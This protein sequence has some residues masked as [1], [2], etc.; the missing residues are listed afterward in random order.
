M[1]VIAHELAHVFLEYRTYG[2]NAVSDPAIEVKADS[3]VRRWGFKVLRKNS[4]H[5]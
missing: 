2:R 5:F 3:Q 1:Y 4:T